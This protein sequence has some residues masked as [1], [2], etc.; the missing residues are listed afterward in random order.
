MREARLR[1]GP[2]LT[3]G[4][5]TLT[6][7][8]RPFRWGLGARIG[9]GR[10][11]F[12]WITLDDALAAILFIV[13]SPTLQGPINVVAPNPVTNRE[14]TKALGRALHR[15]VALVVP[16]AVFRIAMGEWADDVLLASV[17]A[18]PAKLLTAGF[19]FRHPDLGPALREML[20]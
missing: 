8:A 17:R 16:A 13:E 19:T 12:S 3:P 10:H 7:M 2:V 14:M 5:R 18:Q 1:F 4:G 20:A 15:P 6:T 11:Y 9:S